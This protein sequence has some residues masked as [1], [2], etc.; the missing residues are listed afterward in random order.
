[1]LGTRR[2]SRPA[3]QTPA[4]LSRRIRLS[5]QPPPHPARRL[6]VAARH[7]RR[8]QTHYLQDADHTGTNG[9]SLKHHPLLISNSAYKVLSFQDST[10]SRT[11]AN[12]R[13]KSEQ[14]EP[15]SGACFYP[16][17]SPA[18]TS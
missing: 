15:Y 9:I 16:P 12:T 1:M 5:L 4:I 6:P 3:S 8:P 14:L 2:L 18:G 13:R 17:G 11:N 7:Q 10:L